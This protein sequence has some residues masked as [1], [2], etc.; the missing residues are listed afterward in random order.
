VSL[1]RYNNNGPPTFVN[2]IRRKNETR[3]S[4]PYFGAEHRIETY[5]P[6]FTATEHSTRAPSRHQEAS[7]IPA[8]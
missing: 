6:N 4:F 3:A 8:R 5:P 7:R 2:N 1:K